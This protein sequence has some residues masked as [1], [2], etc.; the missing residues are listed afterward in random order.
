MDEKKLLNC[1]KLRHRGQRNA[2]K[3]PVLEAR[4]HIS[5]KKV[6]DTVNT[7]RRSGYPVCSDENGYYYAETTLEIAATVNQLSG[8]IAGI[9]AARNGLIGAYLRFAWGGDGDQ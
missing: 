4:F 1:L 7:L 2:V 8:R 5:G 3:S 9:E 6:R